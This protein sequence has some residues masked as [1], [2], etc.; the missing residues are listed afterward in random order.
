MAAKISVI[1]P[2]YNSE[3]YLKKCIESV[4]NQTYKNLEIILVN[5]GSTDKSSYICNEYMM[6][7]DR[8]KVINKENSGVSDSRNHGISASTGEYIAFLDSDDWIDSNLYNVLYNL[9]IK[10]NS[11]I[12][13]C[14]FKRVN[15][16]E[17]KLKFSSNEFIYNNI[18]AIE[19]IY[20]ERYIQF[21]G[22]V[23]NKLYKREL[24]SELRF[25]KGRIHE[26]EYISPLLMFKAKKIVYT[27]RELIYYRKTL[28]SIMN[29]KFNVKR[30]DYLYVLRE[31]NKFFKENN[32]SELYQKGIQTEIQKNI[33]YYYNVNESIIDNKYEIMLELKR[34]LKN[35]VKNIDF[36]L[37]FN[38]KM[39]IIVFKISPSIYRILLALG[40]RIKKLKY[41]GMKIGEE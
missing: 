8:I 41:L 29:T 32:L 20:G 26:D 4:I 9:I 30:L 31:R 34:N 33:E 24:F 3:Y 25:P 14:N 18:E 36:N 2:I 22:V 21:I 27:D 6:K 11:D 40:I 1:I 37:P 35:V 15:N 38:I 7:D 12:S 17:E 10:N 13:V 5:D 19:E 23:W 28:N 39:K 16:E